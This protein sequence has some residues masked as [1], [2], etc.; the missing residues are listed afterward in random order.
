MF[1]VTSLAWTYSSLVASQRTQSREKQTERQRDDS[2]DG[3]G[4]WRARL[5]MR[6]MTGEETTGTIDVR[7]R[8]S[9]VFLVYSRATSACS[10]K[11]HG[12]SCKL[13]RSGRCSVAVAFPGCPTLAPASCNCPE[14]Y[15][16]HPD[17]A[18]WRSLECRIPSQ[19]ATP[20]VWSATPANSQRR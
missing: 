7:S 8:F 20:S 5:G 9:L 12:D 4:W 10:N 19:S 3:G 17:G 15:G 14:L 18:T 16:I 2:V 13:C 1:T 6:G 11:A